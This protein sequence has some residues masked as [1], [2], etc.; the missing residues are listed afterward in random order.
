MFVFSL[1]CLGMILLMTSLSKDGLD[2]KLWVPDHAW[3]E[4]WYTCTY[5]GER[6]LQRY[7]IMAF[8][9]TLT[10]LRAQTL[11]V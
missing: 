2:L 9:C 8:F 11:V 6:N 5:C 1:V 4:H 3:N 10:C 7:C